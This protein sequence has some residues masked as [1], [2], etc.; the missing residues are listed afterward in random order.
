MAATGVFAS[1][2]VIRA[3]LVLTILLCLSFLVP[4]AEPQSAADIKELRERVAASEARQQALE[5]ELK[6]LRQQLEEITSAGVR[7]P[8]PKPAAPLPAETIPIAG[9]PAAGSATAP[10]VIIE[11]S[12]FQCPYC[13]RHFVE[14]WPLID[15]EYVRTGKARYVFQ[16][17]PLDSLH[18]QAV[19]AATAAECASRQNRFWEIRTRLF[20]N[21]RALERTDLIRYAID[22]KL[23]MTQFDRCF[24][25][26][27]AAT[28]GTQISNGTR[29]GINS[30]PTF[31]VGRM[32]SGAAVRVLRRIA[33]AQPFAVFKGV[34]EPLSQNGGQQP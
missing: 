7:R 24:G 17:L 23:N 19:G 21:P 22:L 14:T 1:V 8:R 32:E 27:G 4:T 20:E 25:A 15:R 16:N 30:T 10:L 2:R 33:G 34:L 29:L 26:E 28:V 6:R 11:Y 5:T 9:L 12:D 18:P 13:R 3:G 31:F